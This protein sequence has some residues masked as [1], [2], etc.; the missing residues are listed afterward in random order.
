MFVFHTVRSIMQAKKAEGILHSTYINE[1]WLTYWT[2]TV[3]ESEQHMKNYRNNGNHL[4]AMKVS[5]RIA[6]ELEKVNFEGEKIPSWKE[7]Q[8][9]L[10]EHYGR[11]DND[12]VIQAR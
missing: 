11:Q 7:A 5:R 6:N 12:K 2:L 3:W 4:N 1:G 8:G 9:I 10:H